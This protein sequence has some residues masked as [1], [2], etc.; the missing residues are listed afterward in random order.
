[1]DASEKICVRIDVGVTRLE[2]GE[3][4]NWFFDIEEEENA[5]RS[6]KVK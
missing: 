3:D 2:T 4:P 5:M 6:S 1:M